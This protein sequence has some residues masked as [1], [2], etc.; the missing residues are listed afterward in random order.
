MKRIFALLALFALTLPL[1]AE[2]L[3]IHTTLGFTAPTAAPE[4]FVIPG[5][6]PA[7]GHVNSV[8]MQVTPRTW[9]IF[10]NE[11]TGYEGNGE[12]SVASS[13]TLSTPAGTT[14]FAATVTRQASVHLPAFDGLLDFQGPSS[15]FAQFVDTQPFLPPYVA[16]TRRE[17][18]P[19][20][21]VGLKTFY[22]HRQ[23][24]G[25]SFACDTANWS[26]VTHSL[27]GAEVSITIDYTPTL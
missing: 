8:S 6:D 24:A 13:V 12:M 15:S 22:I 20:V 9:T 18:A 19:F 1:C 14:L 16:R 4:A 23:S 26:H 11:N 27:A 7:L 25:Q 10:Q 17:I 21:G 2:T 3:V 5:F